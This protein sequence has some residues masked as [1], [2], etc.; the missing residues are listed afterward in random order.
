MKKTAVL[1][2]LL[3]LIFAACGNG[4][5]TETGDNQP[6][7]EVIEPIC[8]TPKAGPYN[9]KFTDISEEMGVQTLN[10]LGTQITV[11]DIDGDKWPDV[12]TTLASK[13][14][15]D[16]NEPQNLYKLLKNVKGKNF[17]DITFSSG[18]FAA[19][20]GTNG[21][22][23]TYVVFAD[24]N[25]DGFQDAF[26]VVYVDKD[27]LLNDSFEEDY[28]RVYLNNGD[29]T[30]KY[31]G[32]NFIL[33]DYFS[34]IAG[35]TFLDYDHDGVI[36]M[37]LGRHYNN[38]GYLE[39]C[40][41]DTLMKGSG[42]GVFENVVNGTSGLETVK[43]DDDSLAKGNFNK[44]TWGVTACDVDGDGFADILTSSYGRSYNMLYRN[45]GDGTFEDLSIS[46]NFAHDDNENYGDDQFF[47][48]YCEAESNKDTDYCSISTGAVIS[49]DGVNGW[50]PGFSDQPYRL[51]G[52]SAGT[53]CGD[54]DGDG[55]TDLF[56]IELAHWHI[57]QASDKSQLIMNEGFPEKPLKRL[58]EEESGIT[59]KRSGSWNDGDLGGLAVDFDN[60]GK[61][62]IYIL[63]SDYP[64]TKSMLFQQQADGRFSET[65]KDA[66]AQVARAHGGAFVDIDRDGDYD[67][68][69]GTSFMRWSTTDTDSK[70]KPEKQWIKVL[71]NDTGQDANKVII[72]IS[73]STANRDAIGA[74]IIVKAG[75][76]QFV[77]EVQGAYGLNGFQNDHLQII[78]LGEICEVEGIE[79]H[80]P[81]K[82]NSVTTYDK[83][84]ANYVLEINQETGLKHHKIE[85]YFG[86]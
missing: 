74:K 14:R 51:G 20:N 84:F 26:N 40:E 28:S 6:E 4:S 50:E 48:C 80:W 17:E 68:I 54:F 33:D 45:K 12:Y 63:S 13:V 60:D 78:G 18:L 70:K 9:L 75:G 57:G 34:A 64:G 77:R 10:A 76:K 61:L 82:E 47:A 38:Y 43:A 72:D 69:V 35:V 16:Q 66:A 37:F 29:G 36:D 73:G 23:S 46:S 8:L 19:R 85:E 59:R 44:P 42:N 81:D 55:D 31:I 2:L 24:M 52:N 41:Q 56:Q 67:L 39:S 25:N 58:S 62:D 11:A 27:T 1:I 71:R 3:A 79:I 30:F 22:A 32:G 65:A 83:V 15:E 21:L 53:L 7:E 49:C 86:K 5:K